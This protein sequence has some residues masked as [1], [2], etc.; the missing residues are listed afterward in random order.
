MVN[1]HADHVIGE[2]AGLGV[3]QLELPGMY[4]GLDGPLEA[5]VARQ[6][7]SA[8]ETNDRST[9]PACRNPRQDVGA[10]E[11]RDHG[12]RGIALQ[13]I[14]RGQLHQTS[15]IDHTDSLRERRGVLKRVRDH[16]RGKREF[17]QEVR[18][19]VAHLLTRQ[20]V[21][22]AEGFVEQEHARLTCKRTR[23][24]HSLAFAAGELP[25]ARAREVLDADA[26]QQIGAIPFAR[27]A[28]IARDAQVREQS[29][30]LRQVPDPPSLRAEMGAAGGVEPDLAAQ[31]DPSCLGTFETCQHTQQRRL[32]GPGRPDDGDRLRAE[33]QRRAKIERSP[34][35]GD[36]NVEEIHEEMSSF[37]TNRM[38]ALATISS[39]PMA[40]A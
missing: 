30:V 14:R 13:Y 8:S 23:Q 7:T 38:A 16:Q 35:K 6:F 17:A 39:T 11:C 25:G 4:A 33:A 2:R 40:I 5:G 22:C 31:R 10:G 24:R 18:Q 1:A 21:E 36:V 3:G 34:R 20:R 37:E 19:T 28:H 32:A 26:L 29:V 12:G 15:A 9:R 27:E